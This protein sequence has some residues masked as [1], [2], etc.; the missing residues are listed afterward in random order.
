MEAKSN[1]EQDSHD[2]PL[3]PDLK[4]NY[5]LGYCSFDIDIFLKKV[6]VPDNFEYSKIIDK[7]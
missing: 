7:N 2:E 1:N 5:P 3:T 6:L 4:M